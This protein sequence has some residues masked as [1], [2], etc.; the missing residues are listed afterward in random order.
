MGVGPQ[1]TET[2]FLHSLANSGQFER[3]IRYLGSNE[4]TRVRRV[5]ADYITQTVDTLKEQATPD[6]IT[7]LYEAVLIETDDTVRARVIE[8]LIYIDDAAIDRLVRKIEANDSPTPTDTPH[9]LLYLR[10]IDS[11]HVELRLLAVAGLGSVGSKQ[12]TEHLLEACEDHDSRVQVRALTECG[13]LGSAQCVDTAIGLLDADDT[14]VR[15]AAVKAL[16]KIGT[17]DALMAIM[18]IASGSESDLRGEVL[19]HLGNVGS[20]TVFGVLLDAATG[21]VDILREI[22]VKSII[23]LIIHAPTENRSLVR[24]TITTHLQHTADS[25]IHRE[26][27]ALATVDDPRIRRNATWVLGAIVDP[28][29]HTQSVKTLIR[30]I[31]DSDEMTATVAVSQLTEHDTGVIINHLEAFISEYT[32][33]LDSETLQRADHIRAEITALDADDHRRDAVEYTVVSDPSDYTEKHNTD[34]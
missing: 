9:P 29:K 17:E 12:V 15:R 20:L 10:W 16:V 6:D 28:E 24:E 18:P 31:D 34:P 13:R 11:Q 8:S 7:K 14:R 3:L 32:G 1:D 23:E 30:G 27:R 5:A 19:R 33:E 4:P 26:L 2:R 25:T 22:A 21:D